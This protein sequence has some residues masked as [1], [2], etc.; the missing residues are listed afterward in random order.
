MT[1]SREPIAA[2]VLTWCAISLLPILLVAAHVSLRPDN[3]SEERNALT[4]FVVVEIAASS[5]LFPWLMRNMRTSAAIMLLCIPLAHLVGWM[6]DESWVNTALTMLALESWLVSLWLWSKVVDRR[7]IQMH[8]V[9]AAGLIGIGSM[10][11]L[12]LRMEFR[13]SLADFDGKWV[14]CVLAS[15]FAGSLIGRRL[16]GNRVFFL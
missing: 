1:E 7:R 3:D 9:A 11:L 6:A 12:Y 14:G 15:I 8:A 10:L 13:D 5:L 16:F 2:P 4:I